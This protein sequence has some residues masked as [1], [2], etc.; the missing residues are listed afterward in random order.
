MNI[1][2][3]RQHDALGALAFNLNQFGIDDCSFTLFDA[4]GN[5]TIIIELVNAQVVRQTTAL[6]PRTDGTFT[7]VDEI[8]FIA[9]GTIESFPR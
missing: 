3:V 2:I 8:E 4:N 9:D 6:V 5:P 1:R 7:A